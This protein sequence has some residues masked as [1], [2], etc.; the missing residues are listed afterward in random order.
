MT[1]SREPRRPEFPGNGTLSRRSMKPGR[2]AALALGLFLA[3]PAPA[4]AMD[5]F[6]RD[7]EPDFLSLSAGM[8]DIRQIDS[9]GEFRA[10]YR[11]NYKLAYIWRPFVGVSVT[12]KRAT[13]G[14]F[15]L[16]TDFYFGRRWVLTPS[17]AVG[18][19]NDGDGKKLGNTLEFRTGGELAYRF[20]DRSRLGLA[21]HH[22]S[23]ANTGTINPGTEIAVV[24]WSIPFRKL[25]R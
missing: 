5:F 11:S 6:A 3:A 9:A 25:V 24:T 18:G 8:Y 13:Y 22:I 12:T 10:E 2:L 14:Y 4:R 1:L 16:L 15:G 7:K 17:M 19:Y 20:D 21:V 23:N